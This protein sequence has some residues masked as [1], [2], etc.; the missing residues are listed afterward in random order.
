MQCNTHNKLVNY[1]NLVQIIQMI[2]KQSSNKLSMA[3]LK[4]ENENCTVSVKYFIS[5]DNS[6]GT[7]FLR[8]RTRYQA[9]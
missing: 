3:G 8:C 4:C 7:G 2:I 5:R 1:Q 9:S 6:R